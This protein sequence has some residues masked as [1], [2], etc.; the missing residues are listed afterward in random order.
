MITS[1]CS[2]SNVVSSPSYVVSSPNSQQKWLAINTKRNQT[3]YQTKPKNNICAEKKDSY[4]M[5][6]EIIERDNNNEK[7]ND[8]SERKKDKEIKRKENDRKNK[9]NDKKSPTGN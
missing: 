3:L 6:E 7:N 8:F 1:K 5:N 4:E 9:N 2:S